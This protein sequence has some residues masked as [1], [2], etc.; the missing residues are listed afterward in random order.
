MPKLLV[1]EDNE[2]NRSMRL[3]RLDLPHLLTIIETLLPK[4]ADTSVQ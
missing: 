3:R 4:K 1:V 2:M